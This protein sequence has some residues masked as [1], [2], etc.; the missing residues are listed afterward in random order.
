[1]WC[2]SSSQASVEFASQL[3][4]RCDLKLWEGFYHE[5]HNEPEQEEVLA[6]IVSWLRAHV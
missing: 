5:L 6:C 4:G 2:A 3:P 1:V